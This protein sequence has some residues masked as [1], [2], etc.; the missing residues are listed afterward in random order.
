M[1]FSP[2]RTLRASKAS[3]RKRAVSSAKGAKTSCPASERSVG[4]RIEDEDL[5]DL[6]TV[7][8]AV[9]Y[10]LARVNEA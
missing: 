1:A 2:M 10:V 5:V 7:R 9:D 3:G 4:F 8:D 6:K